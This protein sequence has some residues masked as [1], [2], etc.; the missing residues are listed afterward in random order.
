[1]SDILGPPETRGLTA[2]SPGARFPPLPRETGGGTQTL[3]G[4]GEANLD[5]LPQVGNTKRKGDRP[6]L[7][8]SIQN[9][10]LDGVEGGGDATLTHKDGDTPLVGTLK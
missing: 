9:G 2:R 1:M 8:S 4:D 5:Q 10:V 6:R 3:K 7:Q